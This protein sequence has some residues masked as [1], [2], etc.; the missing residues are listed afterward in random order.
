MG[1]TFELRG[2]STEYFDLYLGLHLRFVVDRLS[3]GSSL[4]VT[5]FVTTTLVG[6]NLW[7]SNGQLTT[8]VSRLAKG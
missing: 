7:T 1:N 6:C 8:Q 5:P 4:H 2:F 3:W